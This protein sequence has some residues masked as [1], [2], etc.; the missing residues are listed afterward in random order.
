MHPLPR[1]LVVLLLIGTSPVFSAVEVTTTTRHQDDKLGLT[2]ISG[3]TRLP[4]DGSWAL[5]Q[6]DPSSGLRQ[7]FYNISNWEALRGDG[8]RDLANRIEQKIQSDRW[9]LSAHQNLLQ[10]YARQHDNRGPVSLDDPALLDLVANYGNPRRPEQVNRPRNAKTE[11]ELVGRF[12]KSVADVGLVP[13]ADMKPDE[14]GRPSVNPLLL[15]LAPAADDGKHWILYTDGSTQR[16]PLDAAL[17]KSLG[18]SFSKKN[19]INDTVPPRPTEQVLRLYGSVS[20]NAH[21][22]AKLVF[23]DTFGH[24]TVTVTWDWSRAA[25]GNRELLSTW[26]SLRAGEWSALVNAGEAPLLRTWL[27]SSN[28]LYGAQVEG[29]RMNNGQGRT[30]PSLLALFGGRAAVQETL[31]LQLIAPSGSAT[32]DA[33]ATVPITQIP[34]VTVKSHPFADML[35]GKSTPTLALADFV[36]SDRAF[37]HATRGTALTQLFAPDSPF[38]Q[39]LGSFVA[40]GVGYDL[41]DRYSSDLGLSR[42]LTEALLDGGLLTECAVFTPD[43]FLADGTDITVIVRV[44]SGNL[45]AKLLKPLLS[46]LVSSDGIYTVPTG[47]GGSAS[48]AIKG[49]LWF[50]STHRDELARSLALLD[51]KGEGSL[52]RSDE[53]RYMLHKLPP[54][55]DTQAYVYFSDPFIRRLVSPSVKI[56]QLR[57]VGARLAMERMVGAS[58]LRQ[59]DVGGAPASAEALVKLG[60]LSPADLS[61]DLTLHPDR[62]ASSAAFGS[63]ARMKPLSAQDAT[64]T[65]VT[66]REA[67]AY[68]SYL[69]NYTRFWRQY[70]DPIAL[71]F[72]TTPDKRQTLTTFILPLVENTT[73]NQLREWLPPTAPKSP[74]LAPVFDRDPVAQLDLVLPEKTWRELARGQSRFF[75]S[76]VGVSPEFYDLLGP[77]LHVAVEDGDPIIRLGTGELAGIFAPAGAGGGNRVESS[78]V[79]IPVILNLLTRPT[80]IAIELSDPERAARLLEN[81]YAQPSHGQDRWMRVEFFRQ[82][83]DRSWILSLRPMGLASIDFSLRI[84]GRYLVVSNHP[85]GAPLHVKTSKPIAV[86]GASLAFHPQALATSLPADFASAKQSERTRTFAGIGHIYP[87]ML[88][89]GMPA[90]DAVRSTAATLGFTPEL[91]AGA[92]VWKDGILEH[93]DF[94]N[95][96]EARLPA[97][98]AKARFG[99][100]DGIADATVAMQFEDDGLRTELSWRTLPAAKP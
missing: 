72:D 64:I 43:L 89:L 28:R 3:E 93:S 30:P 39:R 44:R 71:R 98:D 60:Y 12:R 35:H 58:L 91:P 76:Y 17:L 33:A 42:P 65:Q 23:T 7:V 10:N 40:D 36:P 74:V 99:I 16:V 49:D 38:V 59:L 9:E 27:D 80:H 47:S 26:A 62:T 94:G 2:V 92:L 29:S 32:P 25:A 66:P 55:P 84:E 51:K 52:G 24:R 96:W 22:P 75:A 57:R 34:G 45:L 54:S 18:I 50:L 4:S 77:S 85:F 53:F 86:S 8:A 67:A 82:G 95:I 63:L 78:M 1:L 15:E 73:Y 79:Y 69:E 5:A 13:G 41:L 90:A 83:G 68:A 21:G 88:A 37:F 61:S 100:F 6:P 97:Y 11:A 31:Q 19:V 48:W 56:A 70:F 46:P 87:W 14:N 81:A 20:A